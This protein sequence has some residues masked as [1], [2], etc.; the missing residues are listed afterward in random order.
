MLTPYGV[1]YSKLT[2]DASLSVYSNFIS[3]SL[4][5]MAIILILSYISFKRAEIK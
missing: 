5:F 4:I 1:D 2:L 3:I